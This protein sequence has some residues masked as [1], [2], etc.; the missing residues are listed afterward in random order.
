[1]KVEQK[2]VSELIIWDSALALIDVC[3]RM[4]V[5]LPM[6]KFQLVCAR[7]AIRIFVD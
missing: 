5:S 3:A 6:R 1:M 2:S 7:E 4:C